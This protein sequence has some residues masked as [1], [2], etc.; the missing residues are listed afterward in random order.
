VTVG[1]TIIQ[2]NDSVRSLGVVIDDTVSFS[3]QVGNKHKPS[4]VHLRA[5]LHAKSIARALISSRLGYCNSVLYGAT[6]TNIHKLPRIQ[7]S[8]ARIVSGS[9]WSDHVTAILA[10][11]QW[12]TILTDKVV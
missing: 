8:L 1:D 12:K 2:T 6:V 10:E 7:N 9:R 11:S 3:Y 4:Y 5:L